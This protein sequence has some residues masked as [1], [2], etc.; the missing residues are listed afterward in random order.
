M[1]VERYEASGL[2]I[3][4]KTNTP[5]FG[6]MGITEPAMLGPCRN[7][8]NPEHTPAARRAAP[9]PLAVAARMVPAALGGDGGGS[10][11]IPAAHCGL[12]GLKPTRGRM[13]MAPFMR[14]CR[15]VQA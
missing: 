4:G 9:W 5:E 1:L 2:Q 15:A 14:D 7:L 3:L 11:R 12:V 10:I 13:T 8:W 6:L